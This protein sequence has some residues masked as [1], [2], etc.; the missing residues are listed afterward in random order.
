[1]PAIT[2]SSL[3]YAGEVTSLTGRDF[4]NRIGAAK[5]GVVGAD[6]LRVT[7]TTGD[8][9]LL[10]G[11]GVAW[12]HNVQDT[13]QTSVSVQL[14]SVASGSRWDMVV[15]RRDVTDGTTIEVVQGTSSKSLPSLTSTSAS[16]PDQPLALCRVQAGSTTVQEIVDLRCW[17][18][19]GGVVAADTLA[20]GYLAVPGACVR[21][22]ESEY[23]YLPDTNGVFGWDARQTM[24]R[25]W[26]AQT[27]IIVNNAP[28]AQ[29]NISFPAGMFD[30]TPLV[31]VTRAGAGAAKMIP[32][33]TN[34]TTAGCTVGVYTGDS[35]AYDTIVAVNIRAVQTSPGR[36][37]GVN[38]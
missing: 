24:Y 35:S 20:L 4:W 1:M 25:E 15:V 21:V 18:A 2:G 17:A 30:T 23:R 5:Y 37:G 12:G 31:H 36:A 19:N 14:S 22:G 34:T 11:S 8:R 33:V 32:Y 9:M 7:A 28:G 16:H 26:N 13:L 29:R 27:T 6:D 38:P 3:G 10:V